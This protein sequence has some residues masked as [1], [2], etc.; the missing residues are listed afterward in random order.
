MFKS[1]FT[2]AVAIGAMLALSVSASMA[3]D[4]R[5]IV[6]GH[7]VT[8]DT[9]GPREYN[10][11]VLVPLRGVLEDVSIGIEEL[12]RVLIDGHVRNPPRRYRSHSTDRGAVAWTRPRPCGRRGHRG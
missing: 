3:D 7:E 1:I 9:I 6:N 11:R 10:G 12:D 8:F 2:R 4:I 5:V